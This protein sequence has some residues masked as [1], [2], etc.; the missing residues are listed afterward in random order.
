MLIFWGPPLGF[1]VGPNQ[2]FITWG[3]LCLSGWLLQSSIAKILTLFPSV[4]R[5]SWCSQS[6][7]RYCKRHL[8]LS[9]WHF[10]SN[11]LWSRRRLHLALRRIGCSRW[12]ATSRGFQR[13]VW[14]LSGSLSKLLSW[15]TWT[16][17]GLSDF[18]VQWKFQKLRNWFL[19]FMTPLTRDNFLRN[20]WNLRVWSELLLRRLSRESDA[21]SSPKWV[22]CSTE[23]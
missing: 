2:L 13:C 10:L 1:P 22:S 23:I 7:G 5:V 18:L 11:Q 16:V 6:F 17:R 3:F 9:S 12:I 14:H 8:L 4:G 15:S 21:W 20:G 19:R